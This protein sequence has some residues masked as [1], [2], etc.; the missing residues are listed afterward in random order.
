[1]VEH[2]SPFVSV[3]SHSASTL[4]TLPSDGSVPGVLNH[5]D[6]ATLVG[7]ESGDSAGG[8]TDKLA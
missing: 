4:A 7:D 3:L 1:M 2:D 8:S 6:D 5:G